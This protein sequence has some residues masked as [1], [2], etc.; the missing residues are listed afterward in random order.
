MSLPQS[1]LWSENTFYPIATSENETLL[2][3]DSWRVRSGETWGLDDHVQRFMA[4]IATQ[5]PEHLA[6]IAAQHFTAM[7]DQQLRELS[8]QYPG[9]DFFPRISVEPYQGAW[10][11]VLLVRSA[12]PARQTTSLWIPAATDPRKLPTVKG[13]DIAMLS[14][15]VRNAPADDVVLHDGGKVH[16]ASTGA[17]LIWP[18]TRQLVLCQAVQQLPSI[19]AQRIAQQ[20]KTHNILVTRRPVT[21]Q[22]IASGRFPVW[23]ANT[24]HGISAVTTIS[25]VAGRTKVVPHPDLEWWQAAWWN[26]FVT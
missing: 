9:T 1:F 11:I 20:A 26:T 25:G 2:V 18:D 5:S 6:P 19:A 12:P 10:R 7:L 15:M 22:Q 17:L 21:I 13:P 16:E 14:R 3:A 23:F 24:L 4:G 8:Q